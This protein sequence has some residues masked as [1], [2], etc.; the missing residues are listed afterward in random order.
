MKFIGLSYNLYDISD[1]MKPKR[2]PC[3]EMNNITSILHW[4]ILDVRE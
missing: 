3:K 1:M 2:F 4:S